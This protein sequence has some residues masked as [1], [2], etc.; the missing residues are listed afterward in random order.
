VPDSPE[1]R[2][3]PRRIP[4]YRRRMMIALALVIA[5]GFVLGVLLPAS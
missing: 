5:A 3:R 4:A 1:A 2:R